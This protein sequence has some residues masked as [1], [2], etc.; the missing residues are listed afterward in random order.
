MNRVFISILIIIVG[1]LVILIPT[2][3]LPVC[4]PSEVISAAT[5]THN[6]NHGVMLKFM[7][8]HWAGQAEIGI[9]IVIAVLG[10]FMLLAKSPLVRLGI[11]LS[12]LAI[13]GLVAAIPTLLIGVCPGEMMPCHMGT[14]PAL[15]L[16]SA[17]LFIIAAINAIYLRRL[18]R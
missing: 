9:G 16:L 8:C 13:A 7:K 1:L 12:L 17:I 2:T 5:D 3:I 10:L 6:H 11:S 14:L 18:S 15:L 4:P